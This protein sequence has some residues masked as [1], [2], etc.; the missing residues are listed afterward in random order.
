MITKSNA[1]WK[2]TLRNSFANRHV[3]TIS[4][5]KTKAK[6]KNMIPFFVC[7]FLKS[8]QSTCSRLVKKRRTCRN[9]DRRAQIY[10]LKNK[11]NPHKKIKNNNNKLH[12]TGMFSKK[13]N[14]APYR[15]NINIITP[16]RLFNTLVPRFFCFKLSVLP[17]TYTLLYESFHICI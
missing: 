7:C 6:R 12:L 1:Q 14:L 8:R 2:D 4:L 10:I 17:H 13:K 16:T 3:K 9:N 15:S 11:S 5:A